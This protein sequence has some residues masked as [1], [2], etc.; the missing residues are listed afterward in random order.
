MVTWATEIPSHTM[1]FWTLLNIF[2]PFVYFFAFYFFYTFIFKK[3]FSLSQKFL[4]SIPLLPTLILAPTKWML[5]GYDLSN[6]DRNA[7]EGILAS[8]G[9]S[10]EIFY[11]VLIVIFAIVA[12]R[13]LKSKEDREKTVLLTV[14]I[15]AFLLSFSLGNILEV[16]T[17]NWYIGQYGLFGA[18]I[19]VGFLAYL[20]VHYRA[21]NMRL[22]GAQVLV[23]ALWLSVL[24]LLFIRTIEDVRIVTSITLIFV[25]IVGIFLI[26]GVYRE[27]AQRERIEKLAEEL[28]ET[29][30]RQEVLFH[31]IGHEVKGFL[32][33]DAGAFASL[34]EGDYGA[35]PEPMKPFV[36]EALAGARQGADS[37]GNILKASNLKKGSVT[38]T[39]EPFD[40]KALT[41]E[42]VEKARAVA[43]KKGL[44]LSFTTDDAS[45][46]MTGD[47]VQISDHVLRNLIENAIN[48]TPSGSITVSLKKDPSTG[49]GAGK[50]VFAVKDSGVGITEEDKKRLFTEGGHGKDS[51]KVNAH[52]TGY[53]LYIAKNIILAH[54][55]TIRAESE[56]E[57][58]GSTFI[59]ELPA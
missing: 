25:L 53:G 41:A 27:I 33:K 57:G 15:T 48:Y 38:Y 49:L 3:D 12:L 39:K 59:V 6:C 56:G 31:F 36:E 2:E 29:N 47:K 1:F 51:Q 23:A 45:Y 46:Q 30:E 22:I 37:V 35:L 54:G 58:K 20:I 4:F 32:A 55:G 18:P 26:R 28:Q 8:Y 40:L 10:L 44:A 43:E 17:E 5:L 13:K 11:A 7:Y 16:F 42:A 19:F 50:F 21:F 9:Y 34:S 14:G 24:V 52:S